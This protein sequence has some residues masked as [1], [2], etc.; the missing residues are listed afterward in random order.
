MDKRKL[1]SGKFLFTVVTA[2]IF[3][4]ATYAKI[5]S[6]EQ[7]YGIIMLVVG[8]YFGKKDETS[9]NTTHTTDVINNN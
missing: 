4:Y 5:L 3:A 7:V 9:K 1:L 2:L 8:F 6:S